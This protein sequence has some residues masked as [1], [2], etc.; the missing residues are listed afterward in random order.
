M[1]YEAELAEHYAGV[2]ARLGFV[3]PPEPPVALPPP[4]APEPAIDPWPEHE[5]V[6]SYRTVLRETATKYNTTTAA[7][8]GYSHA[9][10][11]MPAR[12]ESAARMYLEL[13]MTLMQIG[14]RMNRDHT[15]ILHTLRKAA[16]DFPDLADLIETRRV[17]ADADRER[18]RFDAIRY[19]RMGLSRNEIARLTDLS[20]RL[21]TSIIEK[22][23]AAP[24]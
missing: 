11:I 17:M 23:G 20:P 3:R 14:K 21:V 12:R 1:S 22:V 5:P 7:I 8:I 9:R 4:P 24:Q 13:G 16:V 18:K 19:H 15:T 2:R 10:A 6:P